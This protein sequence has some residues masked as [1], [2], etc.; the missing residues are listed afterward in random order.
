MQSV[1]VVVVCFLSFLR[2]GEG[3][4]NCKM[5]HWEQSRMQSA[6]VINMWSWV[7]GIRVHSYTVE[8]RVS[9]LGA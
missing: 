1:V 8:Y 2:G 3:G 6:K 5:V 4:E 7:N 9:A